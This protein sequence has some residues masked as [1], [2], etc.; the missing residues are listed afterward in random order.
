MNDLETVG[1]RDRLE[2]QTVGKRAARDPFD[3][4]G[5]GIFLGGA[6]NGITEENFASLQK[7]NAVDRLERFVSVFDDVR[8]ERTVSERAIVDAL[9]RLGKP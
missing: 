9:K 3:L 2:R 7:E 4:F 8:L 1:K 5:N 6:S